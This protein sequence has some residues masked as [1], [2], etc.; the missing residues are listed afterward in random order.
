MIGSVLGNRYRILR[1]I[2]SG[3]MAK[4]YLAEDI[5]GNELVAVKVLY[6]QF[7]EDV[8]FI[9]RFNREAKL[10]STLTDPHIVRVLDY[11][12]D[13]D[14]Y[15][16]VMEYIEGKDLHE[17]LKDHGRLEWKF[18]LEIIDQLATALPHSASI[19]ASDCCAGARALLSAPGSEDT[20][21]S[22]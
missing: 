16:L 4:V 1:D 5:K 13:R 3:G 22:T 19:L 20:S 6:P 2:G 21:A 17:L 18:A 8:S 11:G 14:Q 7:S 12:A 15:Y 10:A 9:Q